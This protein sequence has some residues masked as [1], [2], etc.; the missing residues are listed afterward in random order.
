MQNQLESGHCCP[1]VMTAAAIPV[2]MKQ[3][4]QDIKNLVNKIFTQKYDPR[5]IPIHEKEVTI[6]ES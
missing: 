3:E 1:L 5:F 4:Q 2:L 6:N